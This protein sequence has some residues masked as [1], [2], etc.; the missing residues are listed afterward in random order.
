MKRKKGR[1]RKF[2]KLISGQDNEEEDD[3]LDL[4]EE[5]TAKKSKRWTEKGFSLKQLD[6]RVQ[7]LA[8][9]KH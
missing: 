8:M 5:S 7:P 4:E 3:I 1:P 2:R 9:S 6:Y